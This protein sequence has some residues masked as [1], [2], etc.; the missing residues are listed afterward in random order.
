MDSF[1]GARSFMPGDEIELEVKLLTRSRVKSVLAEF[2]LRGVTTS[3]SASGPRIVLG[4]EY[5]TRVYAYERTSE[6]RLTKAILD[7]SEEHSITP[8][9]AGDYTLVLFEAWTFNG[10]RLPSD[11][12]PNL[13]IR[14][15][16]EPPDE[17][18]TR[19]TGMHFNNER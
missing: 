15:E 9:T 10:N 2:A 16:Q 5:D 7:F 17:Q 18:T 19:I 3:G 4:G 6:G 12:L 13:T 11:H 1:E 8:L 14:I